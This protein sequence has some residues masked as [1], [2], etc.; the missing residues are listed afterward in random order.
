MCAEVGTN[1]PPP[2]ASAPHYAGG[3]GVVADHLHQ[4]CV[5]SAMPQW[6]PAGG[7]YMPTAEARNAIVRQWSVA[8]ALLVGI[9]Q[10]H[11]QTLPA[12]LSSA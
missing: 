9:S 2:V 11:T 3:A 10:R 12:P 6:F 7:D 1:R 8:Q 5:Y 4:S